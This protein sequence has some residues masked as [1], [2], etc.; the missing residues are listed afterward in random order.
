MELPPVQEE[1]SKPAEDDEVHHEE[2]RDVEESDPAEDDE[3]YCEEPCHVEESQPAEDDEVYCEEQEARPVEPMSHGGGGP[4]PPGVLP[5]GGGLG[6]QR[7]TMDY[8]ED[9]YPVEPKPE[10]EEE[11]H[12]ESY[13]AEES[14]SA[15][16]LDGETSPC[17]VEEPMPEEE[18]LEERSEPATQDHEDECPA[19]GESFDCDEADS[20]YSQDDA[21]NPPA[22]TAQEEDHMEHP[23]DG[24]R[25][26]TDNGNPC[27]EV[28]CARC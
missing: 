3:A 17:F 2:P 14:Q 27:D 6:P 20:V 11:V 4:S 18:G 26:E 8:C 7:T 22:T 25:P 9:P 23:D 21:P 12:Q 5:C 19:A 28:E 13:P 16:D 10:E 15:E 24:E 1:S